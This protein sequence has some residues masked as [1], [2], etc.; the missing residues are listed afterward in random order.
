MFAGRA[1]STRLSGRFEALLG[2]TSLAA[3]GVDEAG[4]LDD[5]GLLRVPGAVSARHRFRALDGEPTDSPPWLRRTE[6]LL[7]EPDQLHGARFSSMAFCGE[8]WT[9]EAALRSAAGGAGWLCMT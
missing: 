6:Q 2:P 4:R 8:P 3:L 9:A 7:P 5:P 1:L